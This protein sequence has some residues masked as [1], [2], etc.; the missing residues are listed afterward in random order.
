M[1]KRILFLFFFLFLTPEVFAQSPTGSGNSLLFNGNYNFITLGNQNRGITNKVTL[2]AWIKTTSSNYQWII[3]KY[4][5]PNT[6]GFY[7][8]TSNGKAA[9]GGRE[10][11]M[12]RFSG[13]SVTSVNDGQ[14]HHVAGICNLNIWEIWVD[15]ILENSYNSGSPNPDLTSPAAFTIGSSP[16]AN[17]TYFTG[18]IDE[19]RI[20]N[21][22]R[23]SQE[24]RDNMCRKVAVATPAL[25]GYYKLDEGTGFTV[26]DHSASNL[27]GTL[28]NFSPSDWRTSGAPIGNVSTHAYYPAMG[29]S[30]LSIAGTN[31]DTLQT[32]FFNNSTQPRVFQLY[33]VNGSPNTTAGITNPG[34]IPSYFGAF[35]GG[36]TSQSD[37]SLTYKPASITCTTDSAV[38]YKRPDNAAPLWQETV[39][40]LN[41]LYGFVKLM[42]TYRS[43]YIPVIKDARAKV[44]I[45]G[46]LTPCAGTAATLT[47]TASNSYLWNTGQT[48]QTISPTASGKYFVT[49]T[50]NLGCI[51]SDTVFVTTTPLPIAIAGPDVTICSGESAT[52][53]SSPVSGYSYSW[54]P[55]V[56]LSSSVSSNPTVSFPNNTSLPISQVYTLTVTQNGCTTTDQ[57]TVTVKPRPTATAGNDRQICSG[58]PTTMGT[59]AVPGNTYS[60]IPATG[61]S[62]PNAANPTLILTNPSSSSAAMHMYTLF[63]TNTFGCVNSAPVLVNVLPAVAANAGPDVTFC[64]YGNSVL[65]TSPVPGATYSWSP[66]IGLSNPNIANP[67]VTLPNTSGVPVMQTY[68]V[69]TTFIG[70]VS[71]DQV[72]VT[73][74]PLPIA[75]AG[76]DKIVCSNQPV[77][78]G[79]A[80]VPG[81][82]YSWSPPFGLSDP[83]IANP[84]FT[85][86]NTTGGPGLYTLTLTVT[87]N[88]CTSSDQVEVIVNPLPIANAGIDQ[89]VCS[90][91]LVQ[92]GTAPIPGYTYLWSP[93]AA[94]T[95]NPIIRFTNPDSVPA[96]EVLTVTATFMGCSKTDTM[97]LIVNP[98]PVANAGSDTTICSGN[99][100]LLGVPPVSGYTYSWSPATGLN[101]PTS[102][103]PTATLTNNTTTPRL[104]TYT[105][106]AT[107]SS[108][109]SKT[110][111]VKVTVNPLPISNAGN[112]ITICSGTTA[113]LGTTAIAGY[114]Y[115][116]SPAI[117]LSDTSIAN[118]AVTLVNN[119]ASPISQTYTITSTFYGCI[120]T[121][122]VTVTVQPNVLADAGPD[123]TICGG[124]SANIGTQALPGYAYNWA[125]ATGISNAASATPVY[126][127]T[128]NTLTLILV[129]LY[130][131]ATCLASNC[132]VV[133]S[134]SI[135]VNPKPAVDSIVGSPSVCPGVLGVSYSIKNPRLTAHQWIVTGGTIASGQGTTAITVNWGPSG[136]GMVK[137]Y[138]TN[139]YGCV[140]DTVYFPVRI[141]PLLLTQKP[142]GPKQ[143]CFYEAK[144]VHYQQPV[145]TNGSF[146]TYQAIGGTITS[147]NPS[148]AGINVNWHAPGIGKLIVTETST[149]NL[150][151][152]FGVSDTLFVTIY[153]SPDTTLTI[154]GAASGCAF[155]SGHSY[156]LIG[157]AGSTYSWVFDGNTLPGNSN[158]V[159]VTLPAAGV[160]TLSVLETNSL[161]CLG[162]VISK[163]I[164]ATPLPGTLAINGPTIICPDNQFHIPYRVSGLPG[165]A[166][167]WSVTGGTIASGNGSD[168][169]YIDFDSTRNKTIEVVETSS[170]N[171]VGRPFTLN[172]LLDG[173]VIDLTSIS[174]T[175]TDD[176]DITLNFRLRNGSVN[177][178]PIAI[179][180]KEKEGFSNYQ[181]IAVIPNTAKTYLDTNLPT[182]QKTFEYYLENQ[183]ECGT[184][185]R[186]SN[187]HTAINLKAT[188]EE[189]TKSAKLTWNS[190]RGW[191]RNSV[192]YYEIY[193]KADNGSF[194]KLN[195]VSGA[196]STVLL[197]N[198]AGLGFDQCYRIKAIS[199]A[200][201]ISWSNIT[202]VNFENNLTFHNIFTPNGDGQ[203]ETFEIGNI[204]L[205]PGNEL[206]LFNR[207]GQE[208]YRTKDYRNDWNGKNVTDGT[209]YYFLKL[210]NGRTFKGWFEMVK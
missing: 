133:D 72:V 130:V 187:R 177:T 91:S 107:N 204:H 6:K 49:V 55:A 191:G 22:A 194:T 36:P 71:T 81:Y 69:T 131:T 83:T 106:T 100:I 17:T 132:S 99:S 114:K 124:K 125:P 135:I 110:D 103:N 82:T 144:N 193:G 189:S 174:T 95:A 176:K 205:Y 34:A 64:Q 66:A 155:S 127:G 123:K 24:I 39:F 166:Y 151:N 164:S 136:N 208:I 57:V 105:V 11:G 158:S 8:T 167:Q 65:G 96:I 19:V 209:Y 186:R 134:V 184:E 37:Y 87:Q 180:R 172:A 190:Y 62:D 27:P 50:N 13:F 51:T 41:P 121:D 143:V 59:A 70:C 210:P 68:T 74:N 206:S 1:L 31:N 14:W 117:G 58:V 108:G 122:Q 126:T 138:S 182:D 147:P 98:A 119:T 188:A 54:S 183:N 40:P 52:A 16:L 89:V 77:T 15:G 146:Y 61:L 157:T 26:T 154:S 45:S 185:T 168:L 78:V 80:P 165:S 56:G 120:T 53:G 93:Y 42:E 169:V 150:A 2:E 73:V 47:A 86:P 171:C 97:I 195:R 163:T 111:V 5:F 18:E 90:Q 170:G 118:P 4:N 60:W 35:T 115:S 48:T 63:V 21:T 23:N 44:Q 75:N 76:T 175:E 128:N 92:F 200:G 112:D 9:M 104:H 79:I 101:N 29:F 88:G 156:S 148:S 179:Y 139:T 12:N 30:N 7:L 201:S 196:D 161:G 152:C 162:Q 46:N 142:S 28:S 33:R 141:N 145:V 10:N 84:T 149:T 113:T 198:I 207:W 153:P 178:R 67:T 129:K 199:T 109:C 173:S 32:S 197:T 159:N 102:A 94:T 116:W 85:W 137:T 3:S 38:L 140:S 192:A 181:Q 43:E 203:N 20:W 25:V 202:C 160:Y